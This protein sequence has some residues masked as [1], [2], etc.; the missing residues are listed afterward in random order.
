MHRALINDAR[1]TLDR[2]TNKHR[3]SVGLPNANFNRDFLQVGAFGG[4]LLVLN[5]KGQ[6]EDCELRPAVIAFLT[7]V[8]LIVTIISDETRAKLL[9]GYSG[10]VVRVSMALPKFIEIKL[11]TDC[12]LIPFEATR[13]QAPKLR[14]MQPCSCFAKRDGRDSWARVV[15]LIQEPQARRLF[16]RRS[17]PQGSRG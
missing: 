5:Y 7:N 3:R 4:S 10:S 11:K 16:L 1:R 9:L 15:L 6:V 8:K 2:P 12:G 13:V 14:T 17:T